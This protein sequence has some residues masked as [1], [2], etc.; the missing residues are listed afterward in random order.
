MHH[1]EPPFTV[2]AVSM[3]DQLSSLCCCAENLDL[4]P[5][6]ELTSSGWNRWV[7]LTDSRREIFAHFKEGGD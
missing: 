6:K 5:P 1:L 4:K 3:M 7:V 2:Q